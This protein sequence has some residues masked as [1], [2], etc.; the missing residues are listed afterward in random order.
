MSTA[1]I[2]PFRP[3]NSKLFKMI[4]EDD[5]RKRM[6]RDR[7]ALGNDTVETIRKWIAQGAT[8]GTC[9]NAAPC[10]VTNVKYSAS[11][12]PIITARCTGSGC[13]SGATPASG[14]DFNTYEALRTK[15]LEK[16]NNT[17]VLVGAI[18]HMAGFSAMP[19]FAPKLSDCEIAT[20][21]AWVNAGAPDN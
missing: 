3:E 6:P 2:R 17:S 7:A 11:V 14:A 16:R 12:K 1:D 13:H 19:R 18:N 20:I 5:P 9:S 15:A 4:T 8:N 10:D 21:E